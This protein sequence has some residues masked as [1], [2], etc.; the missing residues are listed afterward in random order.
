[1]KLSSL[2]THLIVAAA[3]FGL[4]YYT[5][6]E[7]P[8]TTKGEKT[9]RTSALYDFEKADLKKALKAYQTLPPRVK[10]ALVSSRMGLCFML[11]GTGAYYANEQYSD[12]ELLQYYAVKNRALFVDFE[13]RPYVFYDIIRERDSKNEN[14]GEAKQ[15]WISI[16]QTIGAT[17]DADFFGRLS[18]DVTKLAQEAVKHHLK[19]LS[20]TKRAAWLAYH[21][22]LLF[23]EDGKSIFTGRVWHKQIPG[24]HREQIARQLSGDTQFIDPTGKKHVYNEWRNQIENAAMDNSA[25]EYATNCATL[26]KP[27]EIAALFPEEMEAM[28]RHYAAATHQP[29]ADK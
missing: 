11:N 8:D 3:A 13:G 4:G 24:T 28:R 27:E 12:D 29:T 10:A 15:K 17:S 22:R 7:A 25:W 16:M 20:Q 26:L 5:T 1:M 2:I 19:N 14:G 9:K 23:R 21:G 6:K 18:E